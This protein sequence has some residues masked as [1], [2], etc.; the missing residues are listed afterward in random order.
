[1]GDKQVVE[2][3]EDILVGKKQ[4]MLE[5]KLLQVVEDEDIQL[6]QVE[7]GRILD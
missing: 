1:M 7:G 6:E 3:A 5:D 2:A 4:D